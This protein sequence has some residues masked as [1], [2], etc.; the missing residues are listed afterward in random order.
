MIRNEQQKTVWSECYQWNIAA[1]AS[2]SS[3]SKSEHVLGGITTLLF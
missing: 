2:V 1:S 3:W